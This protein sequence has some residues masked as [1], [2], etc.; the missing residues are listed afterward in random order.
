M[1]CNRLNPFGSIAIFLWYTTSMVHGIAVNH[2]SVVDLTFLYINSKDVIPAKAGIQ[3][4]NT[5]F[6]IKP[7]MTKQGKRLL[8]H[9]TMVIA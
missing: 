4:I 6:R 8:I 3:P 9:Y 7:G 2:A 1:A 5:G